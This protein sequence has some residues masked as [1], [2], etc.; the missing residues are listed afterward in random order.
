MKRTINWLRSI[1]M[2]ASNIYMEAA[3]QL[4]DDQKFSVFLSKMSDDE[5]WHYH[6]MG[7][8]LKYMEESGNIPEPV[9]TIDSDTRDRVE[10]PFQQMYESITSVHPRV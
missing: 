3:E 9:I 8:A 10:I 1:E 6:L 5:A 4:A 7:S 2:L